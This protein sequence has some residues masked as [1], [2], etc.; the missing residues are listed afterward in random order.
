M[1]VT[2]MVQNHNG[3]HHVILST[4]DHVHEISIP[5]KSNGL[6]SS[7][8]GGELLFAA[9]ATCYCNDFYR[10][11]A[12]INLQVEGVEVEVAGEFGAEGEPARNIIFHVKITAHG[13]DAQLR[14]LAIHT[15]KVAEIHNTLR[16]GIP[17]SLEN[18]EIAI[19]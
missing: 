13:T 8:S 14:E 12:R 18:I 16:L 6:G 1:K 2:A 4:N 7:A 11:A 15:D 17:V 9:L 10:E 19:V 5:P 3:M